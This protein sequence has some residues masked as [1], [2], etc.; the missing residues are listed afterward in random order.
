[1][2]EIANQMLAGMGAAAWVIGFIALMGAFC[3]VAGI[4]VLAGTYLGQALDEMDRRRDDAAAQRRRAAEAAGEG[5]VG[6]HAPGVGRD[7]RA[8]A[9]GHDL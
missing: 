2:I 9:G 8:R 6:V 4:V 5:D 3:I 1:M 7:H